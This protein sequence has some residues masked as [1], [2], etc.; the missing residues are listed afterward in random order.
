MSLSETTLSAKPTSSERPGRIPKTM[1]YFAAFVVLGLVTASLGPTLRGL[2]EHTQTH[3]SEISFLFTSK[4]L[5]FLLGSFL[6][7]RLYDRV[8]GHPVMATVLIAMAVMLALVPLMSMLWLLTFILLFLGMAEGAL[9][10]GGN[11]LLVW[12]HR[13]QVGPFMNGLHFF[14]GIGAFLSPIIV[15]QAVLKSGDITWG[16]W[17]IALLALPVAVWLLRLPSPAAQTTAKDSPA[18]QVDYWLVILMAFFFFL[19]VGAEI[20]FGGWIST[21]AVALDLTSETIA[22]Y[23]TSAFWGAL[24]AGRLLAIPLTIRFRPR[25]ILLG[26]LVGGLV[27]MGILLLWP[28]SLALTWLATIGMGLAMASIFPTVISMAERRMTV[29]GRI[30]G[31]FYVGISV[32]GMVVPWLIGQFFESIGPQVLTLIIIVDLILAVGVYFVMISVSTRTMM[33]NMSD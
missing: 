7:G 21:Y 13:R 3:L 27:S 9:D 10:L 6:A 14:F 18:E 16:Y 30:T 26:D 2:A 17:V 11:T 29:T 20:S 24:T 32:G 15:A 5:G 33:G 19:F 22:A 12:V 8:P 1:G 28:T 23:L 4:S 31:W 25:Y